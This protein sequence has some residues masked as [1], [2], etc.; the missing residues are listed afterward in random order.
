MRVLQNYDFIVGGVVGAILVGALVASSLFR[1]LALA[2][3]A[4]SVLVLYYYHGINGLLRFGKAL[5]ADF[6]VFH[7]YFGQGL[8]VG[9]LFVLV[10]MAVNRTRNA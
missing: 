9:A 5:T 7:Q 8:A 4:C 1:N 6:M 3:A 2:A 10:V